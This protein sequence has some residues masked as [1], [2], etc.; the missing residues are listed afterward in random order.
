MRTKAIE[1]LTEK[2]G[3]A[4][5]AAV[6]WDMFVGKAF[7]G[8]EPTETMFKMLPKESALAAMPVGFQAPLAA[9]WPEAPPEPAKGRK[10]KT[11][12]A[13]QYSAVDIVAFIAANPKAEGLR[14][15]YMRRTGGAD[16]LFYVDG[17]MAEA[18]S[19]DRI[20]R[21]F[22][23]DP[24]APFVRIGD[25]DVK[26]T[27]YPDDAPKEDKE[28]PYDPGTRLGQP[29]DVSERLGVSLADI[30]HETRQAIRCAMTFDLADASTRELQAD[31]AAAKGQPAIV[32]LG[33][34]P[35]AYREW[36][37]WKKPTLVMTRKAASGPFADPPAPTKAQRGGDVA[38]PDGWIPTLCFVGARGDNKELW[39]KLKGHLVAAQDAGLFRMV[40]DDD[41]PPGGE[42][43][44]LIAGYMAASDAVFHLATVA[45]IS[46]EKRALT[47]AFDG[48]RVPVILGHFAALDLLFP[49]LKPI[50]ANGKPIEGERAMAAAA[51][52]ITD[53]S[54][55]L[56]PR[57]TAAS[58]PTWTSETL[59]TVHAAMVSAQLD[60]STL[61]AGI[62]TDLASSLPRADNPS[63]Q[64][65]RD[66]MMLKDVRMSDGST[67]LREYIAN[68]AHHCRG[69]REEVVFRE[70]MAALD[71]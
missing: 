42:T 9:L 71:A 44:K 16:A 5:H 38:R 48:P 3:D 58:R 50:P 15:E 59:R 55:R 29:G 30:G 27:G 17:K 63:A 21:L 22:D 64:L 1:R 8:H 20:Q 56:R 37:T 49:D 28:D 65:M 13:R 61:L 46:R 24:V 36:P 39:G 57:Q 69:Q 31:A 14:E 47:L 70:A 25:R 35:K 33:N 34:K 45:S 54:R 68:A 51:R 53:F 43:T 67:P 32:Y 11:D 2:T 52:E 18:E 7:A 62:P 60:R 41:V 4:A 66:M 12:K 23:R 19:A 26:P 40:S 10:F 6:I